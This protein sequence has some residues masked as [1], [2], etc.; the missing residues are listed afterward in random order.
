M[1]DG[2]WGAGF[3]MNIACNY[4]DDVVAEPADISFGDAWIKPYSLDGM[5]NN[6]MVVRSK[7]IADVILTGIK[8]KRL[9]LEMVSNEFVRETQASGFRQR[10]EGLSYRLTWAKKGIKPRKRVLPSDNLSGERK[11]I[12]R[13]RYN[14]SWLSHKI[15]RVSKLTGAQWL[16]IIWARLAA[17]L[18]YGIAY[19]QGSLKEMRKRF[20]ALR[21]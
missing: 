1:A 20:G 3:F 17:S 15:F 8:E 16:Y 4:C 19:H 9:K 12:Y 5:G 14:I 7:L 6:V 2:D 13:M 18:Y 11:K 21:K 10:R